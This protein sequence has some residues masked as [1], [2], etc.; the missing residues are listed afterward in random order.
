MI[1]IWLLDWLIYLRQVVSFTVLVNQNIISIWEQY[2]NWFFYFI[3]CFTFW[4]LMLFH[5][6]IVTSNQ[7]GWSKLKKAVAVVSVH[8]FTSTMLLFLAVPR[9]FTYNM[10]TSTMIDFMPSSIYRKCPLSFLQ[11]KY[12]STYLQTHTSKQAYTNYEIASA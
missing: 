3:V 4:S 1:H 8:T 10:E 12:S 6:I 11:Q 2:P 5:Y 7:I 9:I